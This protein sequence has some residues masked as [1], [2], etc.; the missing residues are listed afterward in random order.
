MG[1]GLV[2]PALRGADDRVQAS[3]EVDTDRTGA[4][5]SGHGADQAVS[6]QLAESSAWRRYLEQG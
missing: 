6:K 4:V 1:D 5:E 3:V 2:E